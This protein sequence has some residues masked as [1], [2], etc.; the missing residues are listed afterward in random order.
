MR[1]PSRTVQLPQAPSFGLRRC[2]LHFV[3][4][5]ILNLDRRLFQ[6]SKIFSFDILYHPIIM[7]MMH[8]KISPVVRRRYGRWSCQR[9]ELVTKE[10]GGRELPHIQPFLHVQNVCCS[11]GVAGGYHLQNFLVKAL[12]ND[13]RVT[14]IFQNPRMKRFLATGISVNATM[15]I[16]RMPETL[17]EDTKAPAQ[18][19]KTLFLSSPVCRQGTVSAATFQDCPHGRWKLKPV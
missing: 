6:R 2:R 4:L 19:C 16:C 8:T 13:P 12:P 18:A 9:R 5:P 1:F 15:V 7:V 11:I 10:A 17:P 3:C 14:C